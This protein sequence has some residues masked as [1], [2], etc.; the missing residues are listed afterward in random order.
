[1]V[2]G[3]NGHHAAE[4]IV[5]D[6]GIRGVEALVEV[7]LLIFDALASILHDVRPSMVGVEVGGPLLHLLVLP[8][9]CLLLEVVGLTA[10]R[11]INLV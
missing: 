8:A 2:D 6:I 7:E 11:E 3:P 10:S 4:S 9:D 5:S 1:M